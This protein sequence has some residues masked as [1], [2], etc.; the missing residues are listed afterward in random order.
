MRW[1]KFNAV[2]FLGMLVQL[3]S[4]GFFVHIVGLHYL[5]ATALAVEAAVLHNFFWH[6]RWT[7]ADRRGS[8][9]PATSLLLLRFNLTTGLVSIA[10]NLF[11]MRILSGAGG[12][13][14]MVA[15]LLSIASCSLINFFLSDRWVFL[16]SNPSHLQR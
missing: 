5:V 8:V 14:P 6:R 2:G 11:F 3:G 1:I 12:L 7:W 10:G 15:N 13:E 9:A 16:P 4:L